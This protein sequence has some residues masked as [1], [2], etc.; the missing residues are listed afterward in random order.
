[1]A[2][3]ESYH[4]G[5]IMFFSHRVSPIVTHQAPDT[6][7]FGNIIQSPSMLYHYIMSYPDRL[8]HLMTH[9]LVTEVI[10]LRLINVGFG[11]LTLLVIRSLLKELNLSKA[12]TNTLIIVYAFMPIVS[13]LSAQINYDNLLILLTTL[14]ILQTLRLIKEIQ[15]RKLNINRLLFITFLCLFASLIKFAFLP[16]FLAVVMILV[17]KFLGLRQKNI[18]L[19]LNKSLS[20]FL[21]VL[22]NIIFFGLFI[23]FYGVNV[24]RYRNPEP[25]CNQILSVRACDHYYSWHINNENR[26]YGLTHPHHHFNAVGYTG[27]WLYYVSL[28]LVADVVP[29]QGNSY[30]NLVMYAFMVIATWSSLAAFIYFFKKIFSDD[31][32]RVLAFISLTYLIFLWG[33]LYYDYNYLGHEPAAIDGRYLVPVLIYIL[34]FYAK[35]L[36]Y[37]FQNRLVSRAKYPVAAITI[38]MFL[39]LG[40]FNQ[41]I[42]QI[43]PRYGRLSPSNS[44]IIEGT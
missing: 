20:L 4:F 21:L 18:K 34:L 31:R 24:I 25:Q 6:Y 35:S 3:D 5:L 44:F 40:G 2:F 38:L 17:Y 23:R 26:I 30:P 41:Y 28:E 33:R 37:F 29:I 8:V 15:S 39:V 10:V 12:L 42:T 7:K 43:T 22:L 13:V 36:T 32:Y 9:S 14:A 19:N 11:V 27:Y 1:M 16:I